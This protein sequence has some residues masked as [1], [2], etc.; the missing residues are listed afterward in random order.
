M[1]A[2]CFKNDVYAVSLLTITGNKGILLMPRA[3]HLLT[4]LLPCILKMATIT[5]L[6]ITS[7]NLIVKMKLK[8]GQEYGDVME[9][10]FDADNVEIEI[11][12][13]LRLM[14]VCCFSNIVV[15]EFKGQVLQT[16]KSNMYSR[17]LIS[18]WCMFL[19]CESNLTALSQTS[20]HCAEYTTMIT[21]YTTM[22]TDSNVKWAP[23]CQALT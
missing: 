22:I 11:A 16:P 14:Q 21:E 1:A 13:H 23:V 12:T 10:S 6:G 17:C 4:R 18:F 20:Q 8:E 9:K 5:V 3:I 7:K 19:V 15:N 2:E